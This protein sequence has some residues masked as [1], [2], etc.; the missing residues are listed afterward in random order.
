[1]VD[2]YGFHVGKYTS[3]MGAMAAM[4]YVV[5]FNPV[6][7]YMYSTIHSR[8]HFYQG[9]LLQLTENAKNC[10]TGS[11]FPEPMKIKPK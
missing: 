2:F 3:P 7:K 5:D 11:L 9:T 4:G 1:M 10:R 8:K 6:L